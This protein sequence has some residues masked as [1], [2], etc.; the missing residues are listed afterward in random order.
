VSAR[1]S[2]GAKLFRAL[3]RLLPAE[4]RADFGEAMAADVEGAR[5]RDAGFWWR[6]VRSVLAAVAREHVDALRQD[7]KYAFRMMRRT[8][9]FTAIAVVML[10]LGTGVNVA[11]FSIV[12]AVMFRS[13]FENPGELVAVR[14]IVKDR[15][16]W[17]V[18]ID[19]YRESTTSSASPQRCLRYWAHGRSSAAHS[20]PAKIGQA[21]SPRSC[22]VTTSGVSLA[23]HPL[24]SAAVSRS[25]RRPSR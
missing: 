2:W 14:V 22:S 9:G 4:F 24:F 5:D 19:R 15:A 3:L 12:D 20:V 25:T 1:S 8:P 10:A 23:V 16:T 21:P 17:A 11:M 7:V 13:P 6:E 18:P